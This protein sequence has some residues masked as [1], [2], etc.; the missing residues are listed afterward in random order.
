VVAL[1]LVVG[2]LIQVWSY[3]A[4]LAAGVV[5]MAIATWLGIRLLDPRH[6]PEGACL[7]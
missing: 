2:T 5:L 7:S 6:G 4:L 3:P 1:P